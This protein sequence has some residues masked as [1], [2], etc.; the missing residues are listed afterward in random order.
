MDELYKSAVSYSLDILGLSDKITPKEYQWRWLSIL[1]RGSQDIYLTQPTGSGKILVFQLFPFALEYVQAQQSG[2][3]ATGKQTKNIVLVVSPLISLMNDQLSKLNELE[4]SGI[5]L[6]D[7]NDATTREKLTKGQFTF[8][9]GSPE[10][11]LSTV[12][13]QLLKST[14]YKER[15]VGVFV[16]ESH[17]V[18]KWYVSNYIN[19]C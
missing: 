19:R 2:V 1:L 14:T 17:C 13:R 3:S 5:S 10:A 15:V 8:V 11:F 6:S 9:F 7:I 18:A 16:D 4:V 12:I